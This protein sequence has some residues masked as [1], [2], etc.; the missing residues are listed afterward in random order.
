ILVAVVD[1]CRDTL[2]EVG[3]EIA[4]VAAENLIAAL[5][6]EDDLDMPGCE[7]RDHVLRKGARARNRVIE[8]VYH[9]PDR[10]AEIP[11]RD[12]DLV[13]L[14]PRIPRSRH[15]IATFVITREFGELAVEADTARTF[16]GGGE[17]GDEARINAARHVG[18]NRYVRA[19][20]Q[21]D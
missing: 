9:L 21:G 4:S 3:D 11:C 1:G 18:A 16:L 15:R 13:Q 6:P 5:P 2:F 14:E 7:S 8:V 10:I 12:L 19:Q 20:V 17:D